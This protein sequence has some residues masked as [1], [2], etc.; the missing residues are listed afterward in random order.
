MLIAKRGETAKG[1][2]NRSANVSQLISL[3]GAPRVF[4]KGL[5]AVVSEN[6]R[7]TV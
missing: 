4:G 7:D 3:A 6:T 5:L 2:P 1:P